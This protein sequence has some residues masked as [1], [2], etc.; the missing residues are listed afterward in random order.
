MMTMTTMIMMTKCN[1]CEYKTIT[2][3]DADAD[4]VHHAGRLRWSAGV[5]RR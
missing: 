3:D 1:K 5:P 2:D 4:A